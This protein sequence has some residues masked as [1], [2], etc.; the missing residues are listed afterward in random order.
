MKCG[1]TWNTK[2]RVDQ[3]NLYERGRLKRPQEAKNKTRL[4]KHR[5]IVE[6][7]LSQGIED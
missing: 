7:K 3:R 5:E 2:E 4:Y 6:R 1:K